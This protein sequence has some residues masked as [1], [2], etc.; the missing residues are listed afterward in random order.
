M[1][2]RSAVLPVIAAAGLLLVLP[3][4]VPGNALRAAGSGTDVGPD[5]NADGYA[6]LAVGVPGETV[7]G[8]ESAGAVQVIY[9]T[10]HGLDGD[11]PI[12]D[13]FWNQNSLEISTVVGEAHEL[14]GA[15][16]AAGDF[17][18]DGFDDLA[19]GA[20]HDRGNV[21]SV[22]VL[23][24]SP[25][26]LTPIGPVTLNQDSF[27]ILGSA[28]RGDNFGA[29][30]AAGDFG[31]GPEDDLAVG[32]QF[33]DIGSITKSG[34]VN[35][36][37]GSSTG[38]EALGNQ[39]WHQNSA[40][41]PNQAEPHDWF[42]FSLEAADLGRTGQADLVV[43]VPRESVG[44]LYAAGAVNVIYGSSEGLA[45]TSAQFWYQNSPGIPGIAERGDQFGF[46]LAAANFGKG[47]Q[48]DLAVGAPTED[49]ISTDAGVVDVLYGSALGISAAGAQVWYQG[50]V[51]VQGDPETFDSFGSALA[52]ADFGH[53]P[54]ADL[55]VGVPSEADERFGFDDDDA[56]AVNVLYGTSSGLSANGDQFWWQDS[57]SIDGDIEGGNESFDDF[58]SAVAAADFGRGSVAD[59]AVGVP[60]ESEEHNIFDAEH[61]VGAVN[62][63]YGDPS[64]LRASGDQFWWQASDSLH[65][66]AEEQDRFG[67]A[68]AH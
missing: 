44:S 19:I 2:R 62:V 42:G 22:H 31:K 46:A 12:D 6:D 40:G 23:R 53:G 32:V 5:F 20:P 55:A 35:V 48:A 63:L 27:G 8:A 25:S 14:F 38:L 49:A 13:Q 10:S 34:A 47:R 45:A 15:S 11:A 7:N 64:G 3:T 21:G 9:G 56:G 18:G 52:G 54:R 66:M 36:I 57:S 65:D 61:R 30:L 17:N 50:S 33:E 59:L 29:S 60:G 1:R 41:I 39:L 68:L 16:L 67:R 58:G 26:G 28:E 37:Y 24:G 51:G 4:A 43:G